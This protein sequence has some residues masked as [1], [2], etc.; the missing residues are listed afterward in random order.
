MSSKTGSKL[1]AVLLIFTMISSIVPPVAFANTSQRIIMAYLYM[2]PNEKSET[3]NEKFKTQVLATS[4]TVDIV[5]PNW[6][7]VTDGLGTV[8]DRTSQSFVDWA[9]TQGIKV[10]PMVSKE[11]ST[12]YIQNVLGSQELRTKLVQVLLGKVDQYGYD[13]LNI[14]FEG[15]GLEQP[16]GAFA[17]FVKELSEG[18][19]A[20]GKLAS[21]A[22]MP[23]TGANTPSWLG[24]YDYP[25]LGQIM[26]Y[27]VVMAYDQHYAS[28]APWPVAGLDWVRKTMDYAVSV[29]APEKVILGAPLYGRHW[30]GG[31]SGGGISSSYAPQLAQQTNS[32]ILWEGTAKTP[33]FTYID[34]QGVEHQVWFE[35]QQSLAAKMQLASELKLAGAAFWRL[36]YETSSWW[37][38][39]EAGLQ[40]TSQGT[41]EMP[42]A[43]T[44]QTPETTT[45][46][47]PNPTTGQTSEP[48]APANG[49][50]TENGTG[51]VETNQPGTSA[52]PVSHPATVVFP[53]IVN[54]KSKSDILA[55]VA[56]KVITG[57]PDGTFK[58][59]QAVTREQIL[60]MLARAY[61]LPVPAVKQGLKDIPAN[62]RSA[63]YIY[64]AKA[65][66]IIKGYQ[67]GTFRPEKEVSRAETAK[68]LA[69]VLA[70]QDKSLAPVAV[71]NT[72]SFKDIPTKHWAAE[73]IA[74]LQ[75]SGIVTGYSDGTYRPDLPATRA[76]VAE[77][78]NKAL[79]SKK[80]IL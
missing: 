33:Y 23:K 42:G 60:I 24:E 26:D 59:E 37:P 65:A 79:E 58:P 12:S 44:G 36:G 75:N 1:A 40:G 18:L 32:S 66:G 29:I 63:Q 49:E 5:A 50:T 38:E 34:A 6:L 2:G 78:I 20:R 51:S 35:N 8:M 43:T 54:H 74:G 31:A 21:I 27:V 70:W 53:D 14:D 46:Q 22:V 28:S 11:F 15:A 68:M 77:F 67:D 56:K 76:V 48:S 9:H 19:H 25:S 62:H 61:K 30:K 45:G 4:G 17:L 7:E 72:S 71:T 10:I 41:G 69:S 64:A 55:L 73:A 3:A 80:N 47:T 39:L 57:F 16:A 13:G 52:Q